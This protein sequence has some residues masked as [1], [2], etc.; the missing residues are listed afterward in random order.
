M[1]HSSFSE[2]AKDDEQKQI[3]SP[4]IIQDERPT[5]HKDGKWT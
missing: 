5:T 1:K 4:Q 3:E 2:L